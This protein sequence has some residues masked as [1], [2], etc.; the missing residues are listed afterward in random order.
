MRSFVRRGS[1]LVKG[2]V[3]NEALT[4]MVIIYYGLRLQMIRPVIHEFMPLLLLRHNHFLFGFLF[5]PELRIAHFT[6]RKY[7]SNPMNASVGLRGKP[8]GKPAADAALAKK[9]LEA[10]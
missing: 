8:D 7:K 3:S 6:P 5:S 2:R 10:V 9:G 1:V 4:E